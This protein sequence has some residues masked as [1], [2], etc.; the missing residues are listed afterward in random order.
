MTAT[1]AVATL[2]AL[3]SGRPRF[4]DLDIA[5]E[6]ATRSRRRELFFPEIVRDGYSE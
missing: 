1:V 4:S 5:R 6:P 2:I 3:L